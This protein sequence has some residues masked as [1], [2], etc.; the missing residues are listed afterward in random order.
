MLSSG[1]WAI[2]LAI[3]AWTD[4][5]YVV[6]FYCQYLFLQVNEYGVEACMTIAKITYLN[7]L[8]T[9]AHQTGFPCRRGRAYLLEKLCAVSIFWKKWIVY[10]IVKIRFCKIWECIRREIHSPN[11][12]P[13]P[14]LS[15]LVAG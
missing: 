11:K 12:T 13:P 2:Y 10:S 6:Y 14:Y 1:S 15:F 3:K 4:T 8:N 7:P 9:K 5:F